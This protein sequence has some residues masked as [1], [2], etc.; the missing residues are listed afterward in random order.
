[1]PRINLKK[2][3]ISIGLVSLCFLLFTGNHKLQSEE[4]KYA[5][6]KQLGF[7]QNKGNDDLQHKAILPENPEHLG[8][9][10]EKPLLLHPLLRDHKELNEFK[11]QHLQRDADGDLQNADPDQRQ[12]GVQQREDHDDR[13]K[14]AEDG[15]DEVEVENK[16][17]KDEIDGDEEENENGINDDEDEDEQNDA[18]EEEKNEQVQLQVQDNHDDKGP[19]NI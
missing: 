17:G 19:G 18:K 4:S 16:A 5:A 2:T 11:Q 14:G 1:M 13:H 12:G 7:E 6:L 15:K 9:A 8:D 10:K 3:C